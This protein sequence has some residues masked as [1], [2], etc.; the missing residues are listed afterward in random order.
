MGASSMGLFG[1]SLIWLR[2]QVTGLLYSIIEDTKGVFKSNIMHYVCYVQSPQHPNAI[3]RQ[4]MHQLS[5]RA[6]GMYSK[7]Y[8]RKRNVR[9]VM[10][11][12]YILRVSVVPYLQA[13]KLLCNSKTKKTSNAILCLG[14]VK[15]FVACAVRLEFV[16]W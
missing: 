10:I 7:T 6:L 16:S 5:F 2:P 11:S 15:W 9:P 12:H 14:E 13:H 1:A 3:L 8:S 4:A